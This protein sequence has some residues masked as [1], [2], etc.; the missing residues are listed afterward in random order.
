[1]SENGQ[2]KQFSVACI[3]ILL[4]GE[5]VYMNVDQESLAILARTCERS[6]NVKLVWKLDGY[7]HEEAAGLVKSF[8]KL[9][10]EAKQWMLTEVPKGPTEV[11]GKK[12]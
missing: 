5:I 8:N 6:N 2:E 9:P 12:S 3:N 11:G 1:M 4:S 7:T 10:Q